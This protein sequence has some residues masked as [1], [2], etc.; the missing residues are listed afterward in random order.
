LPLS[1]GDITLG[2]NISDFTTDINC[3]LQ[4]SAI[5]GAISSIFSVIPFIGVD[6][7][8]GV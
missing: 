2:L 1:G 6:K 5:N 4:P 7:P 3:I 8:F